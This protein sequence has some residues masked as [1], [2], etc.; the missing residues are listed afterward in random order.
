LIDI[1]GFSAEQIALKAMGI[2][3]DKCIYTNKNWTY[4]KIKWNS[5]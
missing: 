1:E 2:A 5:L 4:E 3:A